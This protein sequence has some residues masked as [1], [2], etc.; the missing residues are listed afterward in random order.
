MD[1]YHPD[2]SRQQ[3]GMPPAGAKP[4]SGVVPV[5]GDAG[6]PFPHVAHAVVGNEITRLKGELAKCEAE[7]NSAVGLFS[8]TGQPIPGM[9]ERRRFI[10]DHMEALKEEIARLEGLDDYQVRQFAKNKGFS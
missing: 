4:A 8:M 6:L 2:F 7:L 3:S 9:A 5:H 1:G 10:A